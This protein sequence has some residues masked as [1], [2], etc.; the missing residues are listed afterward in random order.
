MFRRVTVPVCLPAVLDISIYLFVNA[1]TTVS[2][3]IFLYGSNT[4]LAAVSIVHMDEAGFT[5]AAAA[6]AVVIVATSATVKLLHSLLTRQFRK[7][8]QAWRV[9]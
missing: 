5:A 8:T 7:S 4:K 3:V 1:M 2:A 6:M 9:R